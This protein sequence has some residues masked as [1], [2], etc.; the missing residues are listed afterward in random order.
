MFEKSGFYDKKFLTHYIGKTACADCALLHI[1]S[2]EH[3]LQFLE[4]ALNSVFFP[5]LNR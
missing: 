5:T 1:F 3:S 2:I 4:F